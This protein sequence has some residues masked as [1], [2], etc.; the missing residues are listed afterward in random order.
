MRMPFGGARLDV[1]KQR[2]TKE[3][4]FQPVTPEKQKYN[5]TQNRE[6][7]PHF[8]YWGEAVRR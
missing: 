6:T 2:E 1:M 8:S 3:M 7:G 5:K 4:L